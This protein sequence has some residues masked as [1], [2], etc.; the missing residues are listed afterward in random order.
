M[1]VLHLPVN[2][3]SIPSYTVRGLRSIG[4][5]AKGLVIVN[6]IIQSDEELKTVY[7]TEVSKY[8][9]KWLWQRLIR[10]YYFLKLVAW[11]DIVHW[12][13]D[14]KVFPF[15]LDLKFIKFLNKPSVVE[16]LGSDIRIPEIEF[17]DN[18]YYKKAFQSGYE[19]CESYRRSKNIQEQFAK[20]G[21]IPILMP[22]LKQYIKKDIFLHYFYIQT[23]RLMLSDFIPS[24]PDANK[25]KPLIVH[26]PSAPICKGTPYVLEAVERLKKQYNFEFI[27]VQGIPH[28]E[29]LQIIQKADIF[30]DQFALG[31]YGMAAVEAMAYGKPVLCYIKS[32]FLNEYPI[33]LPVVNANPDN[34]AEI[35]ELLLK[36]GKLRYEIGKR[37]RVY[38]E[39]HHDAVKLSHQLVDIY[40][41]LIEIKV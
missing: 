39:K 36:D 26:A 15:E 7:S 11:A 32:S 27:L 21:F 34:L 8:S 17:I 23:Q 3:A 6:D 18:P 13:F 1:R 40:R 25:L 41:K 5:E 16:F 22:T 4:I 31:V 38:V 14:T 10:C 12:Y 37:S 33:D 29:A 35:L 20:A 30:L 2:I 19:Y 24:Y 28:K 9:I